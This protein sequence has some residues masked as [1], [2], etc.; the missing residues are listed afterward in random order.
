M[1]KRKADRWVKAL[2][3]GKFKQ[4][5]GSLAK[6]NEEGQVEHCCLGVLAEISGIE[7][8]NLMGCSLLDTHEQ[9]DAS[10]LETDNGTPH[11][12]S[13]EEVKIRLRV[14]RGKKR[15]LRDFE[16]LA[17]AN[18]SIGVSFKT[19]ATWIEKNYKLL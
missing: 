19:I 8:K 14:K 4:G 1:L 9:M 15:V 3:S 18:D 7:R 12:K 5:D 11:N 16:D 10:G 2:R 13:G 6:I 17:D